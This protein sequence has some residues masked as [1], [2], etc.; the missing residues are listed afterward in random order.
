M[1]SQPPVDWTGIFDR[2]KESIFFVL[3]EPKKGKLGALGKVAK[4]VGTVSSKEERLEWVRAGYS[5]TGFVLMSGPTMMYVVTTAH[6]LDHLFKAS[7][8]LQASTMDMIEASVLC[9]H[10]EQ[11]YQQHGL[12][13]ERKYAK[14]Y[15]LAADCP[16]DILILGVPKVNLKYLVGDGICA[17]NHHNLVIREGAPTEAKEPMLVSWPSHMHDKVSRGCTSSSSTICEPNPFEHS[18]SLLEVHMTTELGSSGAPLVDED[19][20]VIGM[21]H[22]GLEGA[23]SYFVA[24]RHLR[25]WVLP[26]KILD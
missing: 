20:V 21:L 1:A 15:I 16:T 9:Q 6:S 22:G 24:A 26:A 17:R 4:R 19:G 2:V 7:D 23:H 11:G 8:P 25:T 5:S 10:F 18:M 12:P 3:L 13:G 14:A